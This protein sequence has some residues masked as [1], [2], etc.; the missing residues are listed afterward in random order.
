[1]PVT[2]YGLLIERVLMFLL[3]TVI[4][5]KVLYKVSECK[6]LNGIY[7]SADNV[8]VEQKQTNKYI[9]IFNIVLVCFTCEFY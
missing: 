3:V 6:E 8:L 5:S 7:F 4:E 9:S 1:M 2:L